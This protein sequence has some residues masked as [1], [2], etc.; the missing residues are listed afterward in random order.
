MFN[1]AKNNMWKKE[2]NK[3]RKE[4]LHYVFRPIHAISVSVAV[5]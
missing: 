3:S 2:N 5:E 1:T 4:K